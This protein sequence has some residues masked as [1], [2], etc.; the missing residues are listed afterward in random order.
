MMGRYSLD[1]S[2]L[3]YANAGNKDFDNSRYKKFPADDDG[4]VLVLDADW[5]F[6][7]DIVKRFNEF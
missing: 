1:E 6:D 3:I 2:G 5:Y 7:Y 4:I